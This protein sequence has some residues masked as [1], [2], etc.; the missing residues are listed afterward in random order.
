LCSFERKGVP[1]HPFQRLVIP[2]DVLAAVVEQAKSEAP[3]EC[4]GLL[5]GR[6]R[7]QVGTVEFRYPLR[8][9]AASPVEFVSEARGMFDAVRDVDR[10]GLALLGVYHSHPGTQP[11]PSK[12]D[13]ERNYSPDVV[14]VIVSLWCQPPEVR[15]WWLRED[16]FSPAELQTTDAGVT[17]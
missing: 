12:T 10:R 11:V 14:N 2:P 6:V 5:A 16:G 15:A 3:L 7:G 17:G 13:L 8:N 4:C 1:D 9:E